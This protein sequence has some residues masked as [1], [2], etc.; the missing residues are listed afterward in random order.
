MQQYW[1]GKEALSKEMGGSAK[2]VQGGQ[3]GKILTQ[4]ASLRKYIPCFCLVFWLKYLLNKFISLGERLCLYYIL[5]EWMACLEWHALSQTMH[6]C[7]LL[8][9]KTSTPNWWMTSAKTKFGLITGPVWLVLLMTSI[10]G[11]HSGESARLP[12]IW[13][14]FDSGHAKTGSPVLAPST[15]TN[16][17]NSNS[18][19]I[20]HLYENQLRLR[21]LPL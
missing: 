16:T 20:Y 21:W 5:R 4:A 13:P 1:R 3:N 19:R 2:L 10:E 15:K 14:G 9:R 8:A 12:P 17:P 11:W 7:I 18:T 6:W